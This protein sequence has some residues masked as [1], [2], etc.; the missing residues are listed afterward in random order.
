M[1]KI[2]LISLTVLLVA[3]GGSGGGGGENPT[4]DVCEDGSAFTVSWTANN[5][6]AVNASGGGY[7]VYYSQSSGF[8]PGDLDVCTQDVP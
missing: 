8:S 1:K 5:E 7:V 4:G 6:T 2:Y 3:C